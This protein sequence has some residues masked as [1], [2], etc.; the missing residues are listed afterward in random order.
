MRSRRKSATLSGHAA[1]TT[2][3]TERKGAQSKADDEN[4]SAQSVVI[5]VDES[6]RG[7]KAK[8]LQTQ[9]PAT[10]TDLS[11]NAVQVRPRGVP[12]LSSLLI[13]CF[14]II[15]DSCRRLQS[16]SNRLA[17]LEG[18]D[19]KRLPLKFVGPLQGTQ[20]RDHR[21]SPPMRH[22]SLRKQKHPPREAVRVQ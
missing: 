11:I 14:F 12:S 18:P 21:K 20:E 8:V 6:S 13:Q 22:R 9:I 4:P 15:T 19:S 2:T 5:P 1:D 7:S 16:T 3:G 10:G 17:P